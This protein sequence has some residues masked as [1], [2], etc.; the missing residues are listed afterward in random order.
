MNDTQTP[1]GES[2]LDRA[3]REMREKKDDTAPSAV[4]LH[5]LA[6]GMMH[7]NAQN[8]PTETPTDLIK[9]AVEKNKLMIGKGPQ[10]VQSA[11]GKV[12]PSK[13][14]KD[15]LELPKLPPPPN[16]VI[17]GHEFVRTNIPQLD[18]VTVLMYIVAEVLSD[19]PRIAS[20]LKQ[21]EF[22]FP[23]NAGNIIYPKPEQP[24]PTE[25]K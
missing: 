8:A 21:L 14:A 9:E 11:T 1:D 10:Q 22:K 24:K 20:I 19:D 6:T 15:D 18:A 3:R 5:K 2:R 13:P 4:P 7:V 23:D 17:D 12:A 16:I 25:N